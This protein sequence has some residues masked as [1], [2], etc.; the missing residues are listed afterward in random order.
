MYLCDIARAVQFIHSIDSYYSCNNLDVS[1]FVY[2]KESKVKLINISNNNVNSNNQ[3]LDIYYL[4]NIFWDILHP[5]QSKYPLELT[6]ITQD[7]LLEHSMLT[8]LEQT[9][10]F[11]R[12]VRCPRIDI[13]YPSDLHMILKLMYSKSSPTIHQ[14]VHD[15]DYILLKILRDF[16]LEIKIKQPFLGSVLI[17][18]LICN[19]KVLNLQEA[20]RICNILLEHYIMKKIDVFNDNNDNYDS[21]ESFD[22]RL[23]ELYRM[24]DIAEFNYNT[25][26]KFVH[27]IDRRISFEI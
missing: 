12:T 7:L 16:S 13:D 8:V 22:S 3:Q 21:S 11:E 24:S 5:G 17:D 19:K 1:S 14:I 10:R 27:F 26:Y 4:A 20:L 6:F 9:T 25:H 23:T 15:L 18:Y 2:T